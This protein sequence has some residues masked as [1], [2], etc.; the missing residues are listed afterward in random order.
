MLKRQCNKSLG[1]VF[2][3]LVALLM[4][5]IAGC[6]YKQPTQEQTQKKENEVTQL[7]LAT[8]TSTQDSGLLDVLIPAFEQ[9]SKPKVKVKVIAVGTGQALQMGKDGNADVLL[10]HSRKSEDEFMQ[11]GYGEN[12]WDVMY[13]QFFIVGP[14]NDPAQISQTKDAAEAFRKIAIKQAT[15][16]SRGD[17]SGTHKKELSIWEKINIK[18]EGAWYLAAGQGMGETL[19]M[20][21]NKQAYTLVDEATFLTNKTQL[22]VLLQGDKQLRNSYGIIRVKSSKKKIAGEQLINYVVGQKGQQLIREFGK[23]KYGKSI[24]IPNAKRR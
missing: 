8:T 15:F 20:A 12:A 23:D 3:L 16:I 2:F 24:F 17:D 22:K 19:R 10:V 11:Q 7:T 4:L 13:N 5:A 18:P 9:Q 6:T 1:S 14:A 21:Q